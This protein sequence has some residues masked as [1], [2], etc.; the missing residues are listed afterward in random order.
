MWSPSIRLGRSRPANCG[1]P[2]STHSGIRT[3]SFD[4]R[5]QFESVDRGVDGAYLITN[6]DEGDA[7]NLVVKLD[8]PYRGDGFTGFVSYAYGES[9]VVNEGT[10]SRAVSNWQFNEA[11]DPNNPGTST[12]DFEVEH[13]FTANVA[14]T[15]NRQS[16]WSTTASLFYNHQSGRPYSYLLGTSFSF[17]G[18]GSFNGD[19]FFFSNDLFYVPSGPNDVVI[20]GDGTYAELDEYI[21]SEPCLANNRGRIAPRNCAEGPWNHTLDLRI[22]QSV[23][24]GFGN[25]EVTLDIVNLANLF[26]EDAGLV[27]YVNFGTVRPAFFE[28][29]TDDG[30][31]IYSLDDTETP[32]ELDNERSRYRAKLGLRWTF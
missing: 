1:L 8:R 4:G 21:S 13:R 14:Y 18:F 24:V 28:G 2:V 31:P 30:R 7:T 17:P 32:F 3:S 12:S 25:A 19:G 9:N 26:D 6:T 20:V 16:D 29:T 11:V 10:S 5:P 22:A 27:R 23:P 15:F